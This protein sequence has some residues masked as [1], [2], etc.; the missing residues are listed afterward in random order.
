MDQDETCHA[1]RPRPSPHC[2][3]CGPS[4]LPPKG[5]STPNY[6][7]GLCPTLLHTCCGQIAGCFKMSLAREVALDTSNIVLDGDQAPLPP[8][9]HSPQFPAHICCGQMAGCIRTTWYGG[10]RPVPRRHCDRWGPSSLPPKGHSP[11]QLSR[12]AVPSII[13]YLLWP[14]SWMLQDAT[15]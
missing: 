6:R 2:V 8:K 13:I 10:G 5:H 7:G 15:C 11:A 14:N 12:G 4:S 9:G 3:R 1:G